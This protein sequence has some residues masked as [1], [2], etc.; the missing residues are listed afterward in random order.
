MDKPWDLYLSDG[1]DP[2]AFAALI[3]GKDVE[4]LRQF[5]TVEKLQAE[6]DRRR[7]LRKRA[8]QA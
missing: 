8:A 5:D 7:A 4:H 6:A 1:S 2:L 3:V